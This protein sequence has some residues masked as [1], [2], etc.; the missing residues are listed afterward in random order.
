MGGQRAVWRRW[1]RIWWRWL[2]RGRPLLVV[3]SI[4]WSPCMGLDPRRGPAA[5]LEK[6]KKSLR[7]D[8]RCCGCLMRLLSFHCLDAPSLMIW[9]KKK[10]KNKQKQF[11]RGPFF[12]ISLPHLRYQGKNPSKNQRLKEREGRVR[13]WVLEFGIEIGIVLHT[14]RAGG[15]ELICC[16]FD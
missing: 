2:G 13:A 16:C 14:C 7:C 3:G 11:F 10:K 15:F 8:C 4:A 12:L 9:K 6:K 1:G 5:V